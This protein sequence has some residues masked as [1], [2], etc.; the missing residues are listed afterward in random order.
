MILSR[1]LKSDV[2]LPC[3]LTVVLTCISSLFSAEAQ[4]KPYK[5][6][7]FNP[8]MIDEKM[9][10]EFRQAWIWS[11]NGT[12]AIEGLVLIK[13]RKD[14]SYEAAAQKPTNE[15]LGFTFT[16]SSDVVAVVHTHPNKRDPKPLEVDHVL[17]NRFGVPVFTITSKGM[18]M[19]DPSTRRITRI[20][21]YF[22]WLDGAKW[23]NYRLEHN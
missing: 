1:L 7:N 21:E 8:S 18:Y 4:D 23:G 17:A 12:S 9:V 2:L 16:W 3:I 20:K 10:K 19:Y 6:P 15:N 22:D 5:P 11:D 13:R 14:G